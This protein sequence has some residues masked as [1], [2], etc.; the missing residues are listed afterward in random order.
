MI[1]R[2]VIGTRGS[3]LALIQT[4][5]VAEA[6]QTL[7]P[8]LVLET[9]II[10]TRGDADKVTPI[11]LDTVGKAWF[12]AEIE[13]ALQDGSID[14][15]V[16]SLK[17]L[18]PELGAGLATLTVL[19][20]ADPR[21]VLVSRSGAKFADLPA[22]SVIGTD[23]LRRRAAVLLARPDLRVQSIRGNVDTRVRKV[24]EGECDA[25]ILA[26]AG[27]ARLDRL[28]DIAEFLDPARFVPAIGQG[29]LA[30]EFRAGHAEL[31]R[32]LERLMV[33]TTVAETAAEAAFSQ[34]VG[35][36]CKLP[37]GCYVQIRSGRATVHALAGDED[38]RNAKLRTLRGPAGSAPELA[39]RLARELI[40]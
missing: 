3:K 26:A 7:D 35:G 1:K 6:L 28:G 21:D 4:Q 24:R 40:A 10:S 8:K 36:G 2:L 15:A 22:G 37:V 9:K 16:H 20:R 25:A 29:A 27:L 18:P 32:L 30:V 5:L 23:S 38:A 13:Q 12:T 33:K 17:D 34:V 19:D 31:Q 14:V 39:A 11:P